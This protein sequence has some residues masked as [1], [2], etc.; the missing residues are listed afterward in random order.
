MA[1]AISLESWVSNCL[2]FS[3][4]R[5]FIMDELCNVPKWSKTDSIKGVENESLNI[6][7]IVL[8]F[9]RY[10]LEFSLEI[11]LFEK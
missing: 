5:K 3:Y 7:E 4:I 11:S 10:T 6:R 8:A 9:C 2:S 1:L